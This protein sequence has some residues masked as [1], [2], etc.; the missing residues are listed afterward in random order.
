MSTATTLETGA[1][2]ASADTDLVEYY[3]ERGWTD[4]LPVVPPTLERVDRALAA[5][6]REREEVLGELD[7]HRDDSLEVVVGPV[8]SSSRVLVGP[9]APGREPVTEAVELDPVGPVATM[10]GRGGQRRDRETQK[11]G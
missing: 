10:G 8:G 5:I 9:I 7:S 1:A 4:G 2:L 3:F 6:R 11:Q